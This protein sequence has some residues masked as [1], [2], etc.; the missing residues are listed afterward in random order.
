MIS[1]VRIIIQ[2]FNQLYTTLVVH[3][4]MASYLSVMVHINGSVCGGNGLER[5]PGNGTVATVF[6]TVAAVECQNN[7]KFFQKKSASSL[8]S[9]TAYLLGFF[10]YTPSIHHLY[11]KLTKPKKKKKEKS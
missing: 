1:N 4:I 10:S 6:F 8:T 11:D 3:G 9:C 5:G 2:S 7:A